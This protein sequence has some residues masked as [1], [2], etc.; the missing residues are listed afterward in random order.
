MSMYGPSR[1]A[2]SEQKQAH[3]RASPTAAISHALGDSW[4]DEHDMDR[5]EDNLGFCAA[6][7]PQDSANQR[8]MDRA[9]SALA[10]NRGLAKIV[11]F[12]QCP[13]QNIADERGRGA[14]LFGLI[15]KVADA[16]KEG[17]SAE[18]AQEDGSG[19]ESS[20]DDESHG[21]E[22]AGS[23]TENDLANGNV[24]AVAARR[25]EK[26]QPKRKVV[27]K[28]HHPKPSAYRSTKA[29]VGNVGLRIGNW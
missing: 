27:G 5:A 7:P 18:F 9:S 10:D 3:A 24:T 16:P 6:A 26:A 13:Q 28:V 4:A 2:A 22:T 14:P 15:S 23:A 29:E 17:R 20:S 11:Q 12:E 21:G 25:K 19:R 1:N 8:D